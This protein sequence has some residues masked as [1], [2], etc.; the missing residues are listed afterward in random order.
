MNPYVVRLSRME[1]LVV[2]HVVDIVRV[3]FPVTWA[4]LSCV[5]ALEEG[6]FDFMVSSQE[7]NEEMSFRR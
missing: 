4:T 7:R 3:E 6:N 1:F 5:S 2:S